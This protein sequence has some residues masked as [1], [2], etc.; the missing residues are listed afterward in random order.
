MSFTTDAQWR[1]DCAAD[2]LL[3]DYYELCLLARRKKVRLAITGRKV[4]VEMA[5]V[6]VWVY[7]CV[8]GRRETVCVCVFVCVCVEER[9]ERVCVCDRERVGKTE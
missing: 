9:R 3:S 2:G 4:V 1:C 6:C 7:V 8:C 5:A